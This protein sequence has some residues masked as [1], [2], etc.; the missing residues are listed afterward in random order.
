[1]KKNKKHYFKVK[2]TSIEIINI[3]NRKMISATALEIDQI[4][5]LISLFFLKTAILSV[6]SRV[7]LEFPETNFQ[8]HIFL[9]CSHRRALQRLV[10]GQVS[11]LS[12]STYAVYQGHHH[13]H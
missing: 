12:L 8:E 4:L 3:V 7:Q 2:R 13:L 1:M 11:R 9:R 6:Q 10:L 5:L